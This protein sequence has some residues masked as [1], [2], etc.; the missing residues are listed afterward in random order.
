MGSWDGWIFR[1]RETEFEKLIWAEQLGCMVFKFDSSNQRIQSWS[2]EMAKV[3]C[4][5]IESRRSRLSKFE[6]RR[7]SLRS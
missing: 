7:E 5:D 1:S 4:F 3:E 2:T 6:V